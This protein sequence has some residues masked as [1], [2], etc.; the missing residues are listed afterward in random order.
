MLFTSGIFLPLC[1]LRSL[2][3]LCKIFAFF[4]APPSFTRAYPATRLQAMLYR[5]LIPATRL[6][7]YLHFIS[8]FIGSCGASSVFSLATVKFFPLA[9][10]T[11]SPKAS[12]E[13]I[14]KSSIPASLKTAQIE[15]LETRYSLRSNG[16]SRKKSHSRAHQ[17]RTRCPT[18]RPPQFRLQPLLESVEFPSSTLRIPARHRDI[19][20]SRHHRPTIPRFINAPAYQDVRVKSSASSASPPRQPRIPRHHDHYAPPLAPDFWLSHDFAREGI[21]SQQS[22]EIDLPASRGPLGLLL[23]WQHTITNHTVRRRAETRLI[24]CGSASKCSASPEISRKVFDYP[25]FRRIGIVLTTFKGWPS[26]R[27][28]LQKSYEKALGGFASA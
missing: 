28:R 27:S 21:V 6:R 1:T 17:Q 5:T 18:I 23:P 3:P 2:R 14:A 19:L 7:G 13:T 22:F 15:L 12:R 4:P 26:L 24:T 16:D 10:P 25:S 8:A 11:T 20:P 9:S